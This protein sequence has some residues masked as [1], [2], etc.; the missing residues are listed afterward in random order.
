M[1]LIRLRSR[2][3]VRIKPSLIRNRVYRSCTIE[4]TMILV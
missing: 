2:E 1:S 4:L 3:W